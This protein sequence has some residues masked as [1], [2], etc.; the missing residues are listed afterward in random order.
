MPTVASWQSVLNSRVRGFRLASEEEIL[1]RIRNESSG[2][3]LLCN[4]LSA[5]SRAKL[6]FSQLRVDA[7]GSDPQK[8][9]RLRLIST[10][11]VHRR[12]DYLAFAFLQSP[13][14][15]PFMPI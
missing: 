2:T 6:M 15:V 9:G 4:G 5:T 10:S 1:V 12:S 3:Q 11:A 14:E 8:T 13:A 7:A